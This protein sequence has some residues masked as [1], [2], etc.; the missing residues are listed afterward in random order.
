[1]NAIATGL[2]IAIFVFFLLAFLTW[3]DRDHRGKQ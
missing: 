3:V 1:M 2:T